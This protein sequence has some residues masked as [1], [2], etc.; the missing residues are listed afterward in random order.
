MGYLSI[1]N[2]YKDQDILLFRRCYALEKIHGTSAHLSWRPI[3]KHDPIRGN[4]L[5]FH[6][7][8]APSAAFEALFNHEELEQKL[9]DKVGAESVTIFGEAYGGKLQAMSGTYGKDMKF[10]VFD[11]QINDLWLSVPQAADFANNIGLEFVHYVEIPAELEAIDRER[12]A[13]SVQAIR[14]GVGVG[15]KREGIIL[16][17]LVEL[18]KNNNERIICKHKRDE[19]METKTPRTVDPEKLKVLEDATAV[20]EEWVTARRLEHVLDKLPQPWDIKQT[21]LV[22]KAMI[23]DVVREGEGEFVDSPDVRKAV[24]KKAAELFKVYFRNRLR[25]MS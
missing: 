12:D 6:P 24:G 9:R 22:I 1:S 25:D 3:D 10:V 14:N 15:K 18:R 19:F 7:G 4:K 13:D 8:G 20:A 5:H 16:R 2:L 11:V 23:E 17:P 21:P